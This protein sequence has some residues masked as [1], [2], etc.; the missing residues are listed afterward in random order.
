MVPT[1]HIEELVPIVVI[2]SLCLMFGWLAWITTRTRYLQAKNQIELNNR[3]VGGI[4]SAQDILAL[5]K[6]KEGRRLLETISV[7]R[8]TTREEIV[9]SVKRGII[10]TMVGAGGL[11]LRVIFPAG[12][13]VFIVASVLVGM[14]GVGTL[15]SSFVVFRMSRSWGLL[16]PA[17][18][19]APDNSTTPRSLFR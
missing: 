19:P 15:I 9:R 16:P 11:L 14:V 8:P 13:G 6:T 18:Q 3:L 10:F 2:P 12:Y 4:S 7:E 5:T 1:I 17:E